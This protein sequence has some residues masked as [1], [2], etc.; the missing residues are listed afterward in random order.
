M[1]SGRRGVCRR[2][3]IYIFKG[4]HVSMTLLRADPGHD[5]NMSVRII[6]HATMHPI[7]SVTGHLGCNLIRLIG[8]FKSCALWITQ[9]LN[10]RAL[11]DAERYIDG[12]KADRGYELRTL[13][14]K[15][16]FA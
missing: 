9:C 13:I 16:T 15:I 8:E 6:I 7:A 4:K 14:S 12:G 11:W 5:G 3:G 2:W 10:N 1:E